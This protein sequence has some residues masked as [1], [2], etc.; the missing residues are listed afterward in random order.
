MNQSQKVTGS[1]LCGRVRLDINNL[2]RNVVACHCQQCR[3]Q[4]GHFVAA[5]RAE[6]S[7]LVITGCEN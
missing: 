4:T 5:T 7:K 2:D 1:C 6:N 3:K